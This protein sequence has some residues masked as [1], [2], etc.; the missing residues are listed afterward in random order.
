V[1]SE[2]K[3]LG[4]YVTSGKIN[5]RLI[6]DTGGEANRTTETSLRNGMRISGYSASSMTVDVGSRVTST[7][8]DNEG[9]QY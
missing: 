8:C 7:S 6:L 1:A 5:L 4:L 3:C 9:N 2:R